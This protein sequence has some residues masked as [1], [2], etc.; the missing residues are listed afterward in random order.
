MLELSL[1][2]IYSNAWAYSYAVD[3]LKTKKIA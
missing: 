1:E 2:I 3:L